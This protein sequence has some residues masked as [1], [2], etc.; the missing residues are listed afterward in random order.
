MGWDELCATEFTT[1]VDVRFQRE[2]HPGRTDQLT[3]DN[4]LCATNN[5]GAL[6]SH[7]GEVTHED[8]LFLDLP[9]LLDHELTS[10]IEGRCI[11]HI[12]FTTLSL[13]VSGRTKLIV[14]KT[15]LKLIT[16]EVSDAAEFR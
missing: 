6:G 15:Q 3:Y 14:K 2:I 10:D 7:Q 12:V 13:G 9:C 11:R 8:L 1:T 16:C 4:P 5:E